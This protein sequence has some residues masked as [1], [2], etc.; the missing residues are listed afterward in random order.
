MTIA[1]LIEKLKSEENIFYISIQNWADFK[2]HSLMGAM[3]E[4]YCKLYGAIWTFYAMGYLTETE[5]PELIN[6]LDAMYAQALKNE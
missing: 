3:F 6:D 1:E 5:R 2:P 4:R